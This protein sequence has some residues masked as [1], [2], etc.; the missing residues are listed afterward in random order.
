[1]HLSVLFLS[2]PGSLYILS[3]GSSPVC[4]SGSLQCLSPVSRS[5]FPLSQESSDQ[6]NSVPW[7]SVPQIRKDQTLV[8]PPVWQSCTGNYPSHLRQ[9]W[10]ALS[11]HRTGQPGHHSASAGKYPS[12]EGSPD[13]K[14]F[15]RFSSLPSPSLPLLPLPHQNRPQSCLHCR[16]R[17][18]VHSYWSFS[19]PGFP[20]PSQKH[21]PPVVRQ[22]CSGIHF[23]RY[24]SLR[25]THTVPA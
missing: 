25:Y 22:K 18:Y 9:K 24:T 16:F 2:S 7:S 15:F 23:S 20:L 21:L 5:L 3:P 12:A 17:R 4:S 19:Y 10:S 6:G 8:F 11:P 1:M 13:K 14:R